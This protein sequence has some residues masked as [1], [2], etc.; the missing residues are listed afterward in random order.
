[1]ITRDYLNSN[2]MSL[3]AEWMQSHLIPNF[4]DDIEYDNVG[5]TITC[6]YDG[7]TL[8]T[9]SKTSATG[10]HTITA[11]KS[12]TVSDNITNVAS[13]VSYACNCE[14]GALILFDTSGGILITKTNQDKVAFVFSSNVNNPN[15][16]R[17][18]GIKRVA[19]GDTTLNTTFGFT[20]INSNQ[21]HMVSFTTYCPYGETSFTP[22]AFWLL[23]SDSR[24]DTPMKCI[25]N[26]KQYLSNGYWAIL[27]GDVQNE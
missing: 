9:I 2:D 7:N 17:Q 10:T 11:Y 20:P 25:I 4:F 16:W 1:M 21:V 26:G 13:R 18:A 5:F 23:E 12:V 27:D 3:L 15:S 19:W 6:K 14:N 22:Y 8:L 24:Y